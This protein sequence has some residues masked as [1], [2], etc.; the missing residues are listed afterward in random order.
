MTDR[1][2]CPSCLGAKHVPKLGGMIG[3]CNYC[4]AKGD[5]L[6]SE[7]VAP[8]VVEIETPTPEIVKAVSAAIPSQINRSIPIKSDTAWINDIVTAKEPS[9]KVDPK[10]TTYRKKR[11]V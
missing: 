2:R 8:V 4:K 10:R 9:V 3:D 11:E 7:I 1:V 5:V 6:A